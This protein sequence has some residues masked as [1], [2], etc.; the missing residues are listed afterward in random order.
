M[1]PAESA[2]IARKVPAI[3][4]MGGPFSRRAANRSIELD[5]ELV[6]IA[7]RIR[8][9]FDGDA[10]RVAFLLAFEDPYVADRLKFHLL[11]LRAWRGVGIAPSAGLCLLVLTDREM[12]AP[13]LREDTAFGPVALA[14]PADAPPECRWNTLPSSR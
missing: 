11:P 1:Q 5:W 14:S 8:E 13:L 9:A 2:A 12:P 10:A 6:G 7:A 3:R 4:T